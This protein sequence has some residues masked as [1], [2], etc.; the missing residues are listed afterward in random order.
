MA[1]PPGADAP[2]RPADPRDVPAVLRPSMRGSFHRASIPVAVVLTVILAVRASTGG[3]RAAVIVYGVCVTAMLTVS[4]V[5]H[6]PRYA[7]RDRR[8]L[9]RL[10]HSMILVGTAGTYTAV[11]VL[12]LDGTTRVV[13][14]VVAWT[15]APIGVAIRMLWLDAPSGLV[16]AVYLVAG[17]QLVL[18]VPAY[19]RG[20]TGVELLLLAIGGGLY[21]IGAV[22]YA[23]KRPN[24]WP[25]VFGYHEIFHTLV[26]AAA[27]AHWCSVFLLT[28]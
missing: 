16:A 27:F 21:T 26:V 4:G 15:I 24:P 20:L 6:S 3:E 5:Y 17:W 12:G 14:L 7:S 10:D 9:R 11:I 13:L 8:I 18:D 2:V 28:G 23:L 1:A 19:V 25:A 22:V